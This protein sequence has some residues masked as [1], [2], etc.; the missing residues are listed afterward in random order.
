MHKPRRRV[1][2]VIGQLRPG[3]IETWLL[4]VM[5]DCKVLR[6]LSALCCVNRSW[7]GAYRAEFERLDI[8]IFVCPLDRVPLAFLRS[9]PTLVQRG[10]FEIIHSHLAW[11]S[12]IVSC[13]A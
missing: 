5:K 1:L 11:L 4:N 13:A 8:P 12:G 9:F 6:D 3:G 10:K 7:D 2:H